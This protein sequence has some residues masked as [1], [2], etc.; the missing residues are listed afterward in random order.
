MATILSSLS[1]GLRKAYRKA[2]G[3][4]E[5]E[6]EIPV[7]QVFFNATL[8]RYVTD[9]VE[10]LKDLHADVHDDWLRLYASIDVKGLTANLSVDLKLLQMIFNKD[11][12]LLVFEQISDTQIISATFKNTFQKILVNSAVFFYQKVLKKDPLGPILQ[13][14][15]IVSVQDGLLNLDLNRWLG[16]KRSIMESLRK[17]HVNHAELREAKL[18]LIGNVNLSALFTKGRDW[19]S[20]QD[21]SSD[22]I[23]VT[24]S[25]GLAED[26][27]LNPPTK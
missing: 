11:T 15:E 23:D 24:D 9:N 27:V 21:E 17:L 14:F 2:E 7:S 8:K 26:D 22:L 10:L 19:Q 4:I 18:V 6:R 16:D 3:F 25:N 12:Q 5:E 20:L 13:H 1:K